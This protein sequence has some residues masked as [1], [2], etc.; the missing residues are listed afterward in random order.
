MA[1]DRDDAE[2]LWIDP[3]D[4]GILPLDGFHLSRS[5]R[6]TLNGARFAVRCDTRVRTGHAGCAEPMPD[7][8]ETWIND[9]IF[10]SVHRVAPFRHHP[11]RRDMGATTLVGGLYGLSLGSAFFGESMF[12][13]ADNASKVAPPIWSPG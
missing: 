1:R 5:M 6:K 11:Q 2:L 9:E 4:R 8:K 13:R 12:S 3:E 7:R 10:A